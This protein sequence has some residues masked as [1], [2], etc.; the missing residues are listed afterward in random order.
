MPDP[1]GPAPGPEEPGPA[2]TPDGPPT[3]RDRLRLACFHFGADVGLLPAFGAF[4]G[5]Q[6]IEPDGTDRVYAI[7]D[8]RVVELPARPVAAWSRLRAA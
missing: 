2:P 7:A 8:D 3:G 5:M 6:D 4:T 1:T